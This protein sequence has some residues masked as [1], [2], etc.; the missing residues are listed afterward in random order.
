MS[1]TRALTLTLL[2]LLLLL[3]FSSCKNEKKTEAGTS[4]SKMKEVMAIHDEIMPKMGN[5]GSLVGK[6]S[7]QEDSTEIGLKYKSAR[8]DLQAAHKS[9]MEWMQGFGNKFD[10]DEILNGKELSEQKLKWL[11]EEEQKIKN[12]KD[13]I[14]RSLENAEALLKK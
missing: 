1:T 8:E 14:N 11:L 4:A 7:S 9:M 10:S 2:S 6:L 3:A 12:L 13:D 5:F